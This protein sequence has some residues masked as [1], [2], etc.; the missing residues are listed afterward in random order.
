V[1]VVVKVVVVKVVVVK[2]VVVKVVVVKVVVMMLVVPVLPSPGRDWASLAPWLSFAICL[3]NCHSIHFISFPLSHCPDLSGCVEGRLFAQNRVLLPS[4]PRS[5][6]N[7][8]T[9]LPLCSA[10]Q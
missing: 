6:S 2:V 4:L 7:Q 5:K 3:Y 1:V 8:K 10:Q 9:T